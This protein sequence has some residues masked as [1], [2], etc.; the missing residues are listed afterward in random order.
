[1]CFVFSKCQQAGAM[2]ISGVL[3]FYKQMY[4]KMKL[5]DCLFVIIS[6]ESVAV[7]IKTHKKALVRQMF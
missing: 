3:L 7:A 1:M 2:G 5:L 4:A 6:Q